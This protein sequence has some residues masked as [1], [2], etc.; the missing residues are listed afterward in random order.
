MEAPP[1][2]KRVFWVSAAVG[3]SVMAF[4]VL[5]LFHDAARTNPGQW[6]RWFIGAALVHD[7]VVAPLVFAVA[8]TTRKLLPPALVGIV[9]GAFITT[10]VLAA[11]T[12]PFLRGYG[13]NPLNPSILP[14]NYAMNLL[15]LT[16]L[17]WLVAGVALLRRWRRRS[18]EPRATSL[19]LAKRNH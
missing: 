5:G 1:V 16:G 13:E 17:V 15:W 9:N 7:F 3:V 14:N 11:V 19:N 12:Y 4:G 8:M 6:V 2:N 10:G 18:T